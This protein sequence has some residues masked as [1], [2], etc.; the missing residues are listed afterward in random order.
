MKTIRNEDLKNELVRRLNA[1]DREAKPLWGKMNV[2]QM[3]S[4]LAQTAEWPFVRSV[5]DRSNLFSRTIIKPLVIYV[6]PMPKEVK[7]P[8]Q[9]DQLQGGR[10]PQDFDG[11]R[12]LVIEA[13]NRL[14]TLPEDHDCR[15]HPYFGKLSAKE[16]ACSP[17]NTSTTTSANSVRDVTRSCD[18]TNDP[19]SAAYKFMK[20]CPECKKDYVDDSLLYCLDD[21]SLL[22]QGSLTH[23]HVTAIIT[24]DRLARESPTSLIDDPILLANSSAAGKANGGTLRPWRKIAVVAVTGIALITLGWFLSFKLG[25]FRTV[26]IAKAVP[27]RFVIQGPEKATQ[28]MTPAISPDGRMFIFTALMDGYGQLWQRAMDSTVIQPVPGVT[29]LQGMHVWSPDSR[30]IAFFADGKLKRLDFAG[31]L[32]RVLC[33]LPENSLPGEGASAWNKDGVILFTSNGKI[34]RASADGGE[35]QMLLG[36]DNSDSNISYRWPFLLP[37][38]SHFLFSR[39]D[40]NSGTA[41]IYIGSLDNSETTRLAVADSQAIYFSS[42]TGEYLLYARGSSLF[43]QAFDAGQMKFTGEPVTVSDTVS[44][45]ATRRGMFDASRTGSI[46]FSSNS[47]E[48]DQQ[49]IWVDRSG[50]AEGTVGGIGNLRSPVISPDGQRVSVTRKDNSFVTSDISVID[51]VRGTASRFTFSDGEDMFSHWSPDGSRI[52]WTSAH[53]AG[54]Q[55]LQKAASGAGENEVLAN[56]DALVSIN[57]WSSDGKFIL[58]DRYSLETKQ[59]LWVLPLEG[60][61]QPIAYLQGPFNEREGRFSPDSRWVAYTSN[62]SVRPEVFLQSYPASAVKIQISTN[63]GSNPQWRGDGKELFYITS[64]NKLASVEVKPN[65]AGAGCAEAA[66]RTRTSTPAVCRVSGRSAFSICKSGPAG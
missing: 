34:Y 30:S 41:E 64:D 57:S 11:D 5:E 44:V 14:G 51:L 22:L 40:K 58:F 1:L 37:D 6:L 45:S 59:D 7:M 63:G 2:A 9:V 29:G 47:L 60:D 42:A 56:S 25:Y 52:C 17:T 38:D 13:L 21:G 16:W 23:E 50:K 32:P 36:A 53:G 15:E 3:V 55:I 46:V 20:R 48:G 4:H 31:G 39:D 33:D 43:A 19:A 12:E 54:Y 27:M 66:F 28:L 8:A 35:P 26:E 18:V 61:R 65:G 49:L 10:P 62:E 24:G